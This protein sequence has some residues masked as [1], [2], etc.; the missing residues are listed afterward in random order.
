VE[1]GVVHRHAI[2]LVPASGKAEVRRREGVEHGDAATIRIHA[3]D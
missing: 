1:H 2:R 3:G